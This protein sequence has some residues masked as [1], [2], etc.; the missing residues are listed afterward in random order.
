MS[1]STWRVLSGYATYQRT[2]ISMT[3]GGKCAPVKLIAMVASLM[4]HLLREEDH[5]SNRLK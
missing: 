1:A 2:P 4:M 5:T 3:A